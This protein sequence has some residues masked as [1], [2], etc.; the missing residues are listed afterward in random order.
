LTATNDFSY[1]E[2]LQA[3]ERSQT[4]LHHL[5][6]SVVAH[7]GQ[8]K[9]VAAVIEFCKQP[10]LAEEIVYITITKHR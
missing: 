5:V 3:L 7:I 6:S 1:C 2:K 9:V 4:E 10:Y 8:D